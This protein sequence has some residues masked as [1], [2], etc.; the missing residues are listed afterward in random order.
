MGCGLGWWWWLGDGGSWEMVV[1]GVW[2]GGG[3]G[4]WEDGWGVVVVGVW[5]GVCGDG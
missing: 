4:V 3:V 5:F 1:V 2:F